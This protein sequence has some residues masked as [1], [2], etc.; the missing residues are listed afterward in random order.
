M[1]IR[2]MN[3]KSIA[4][5]TA[6]LLSVITVGTWYRVD[7]QNTQPTTQKTSAPKYTNIRNGKGFPIKGGGNAFQPPNLPQSN[8]PDES[9]GKRGIIGWDDRVPMLSRRYPWSAIGRVQGF[10]RQGKG[11]HC[12]G[13][14]ISDD[15]VLTNAHCVINP[16]TGQFSQRIQFLP[17]V[18]NGQVTNRDDVAEVTEVVYG[19]DFSGSGLENQVNDWALLKLDQPIG[20]KYGYLGWKALPSSTLIRN[21]G[22]YIFVGYSG[23]FPNNNRKGYEFFTAGPG[24][25]A[26][27][28]NGCS[29][30]REERGV[31]FHD[32]DTTGGSSGGAIIAIIGGQPRIVA[33]NNAEIVNQRTGQGLINLAVKIDFLDRL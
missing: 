5:L 24:W 8:K 32:C 1:M 15:V 30:V 26:S 11:Y 23:D 25:T 6:A 31:L 18:I 27:V 10:D 21:Q 3:V 2:K 22:K 12:T 7:A 9:E 4:V 29:I 19:T 14:L 33:L 17:N 16:E 20:L 13:T 28:Q